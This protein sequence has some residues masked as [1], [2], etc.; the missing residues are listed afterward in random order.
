MMFSSDSPS[1]HYTHRQHAAAIV[2]AVCAAVLARWI[3]LSW[4]GSELAFW[5]QWDAELDHLFRPFAE[6]TLTT[7]M[8]FDAHNEHRLALSRLL[9][10]ALFVANERQF[11]NLVTIFANALFYAIALAAVAMPVFRRERGAALTLTAITFVAIF[12]SLHGW[13]N[14]LIGMQNAFYLMNAL[15]IFAIGAVTLKAPGPARMTTAC[16]VSACVL[17]TMASGLLTAAAL[18]VA[19]AILWRDRLIDHRTAW[20]LLAGM[21]VVLGIGLA[22]YISTKTTYSFR[23]TGIIEFLSALGR[24]ASWPFDGNVWFGFVAWLPLAVWLFQ[25]WHR[26]GMELPQ[27]RRYEVF[28]ATTAI[29]VMMQIA[30][31]AVSRG[32]GFIGVQSRYT[33]ILI[34]GLIANALLARLLIGRMPGGRRQTAATCAAIAASLLLALGLARVNVDAY[35]ELVAH[36]AAG[37]VNR[38]AVRA[39]VAGNATAF[40]GKTPF[41]ISYPVRHRVEQLLD[42]PTI[43]AMLPASVR[44]PLDPHWNGC[45]LLHPF[46]AFPTTPAR[47]DA[48]GTYSPQSGNANRGT[49][50]STP[51]TTRFSHLTVRIAGYL[52]LPQTAFDLVSADGRTDSS[53]IVARVSR[54][55]WLAHSAAVPSSPFVMRAIDDTPD[56]W[57]AFAQPSEQGRLSAVVATIRAEL[58]RLTSSSNA[59]DTD[60][61]L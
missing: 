36:R 59:P 29:W 22:L 39:Y 6:G 43:R 28:L 57:F 49:C 34:L 32:K 10:I 60:D 53:V 12:G 2:I 13:Q 38:V 58:R 45:T 9:G 35:G 56:Y 52:G 5:D 4:F 23:P 61:A 46:G 37:S 14:S 7:G 16:I 3:F 48:L 21:S 33:D 15:T 19:T 27:D 54:E 26:K 47:V 40:E 51:I 8:L 11:D 20:R 1:G 42:D 44:T 17:M 24:T 50:T 55:S 18:I 25:W 30:A 31:V 41:E